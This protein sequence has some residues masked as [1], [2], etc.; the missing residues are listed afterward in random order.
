MPV[1]AEVIAVLAM[2]A[3][4]AATFATYPALWRSFRDE[5]RRIPPERRPRAIDWG[6]T[7]L[8]LA[9]LAAVLV[10]VAPWGRADLA[11]IIL[12]GIGGQMLVV[13]V[14]VGLQAVQDTRRASRPRRKS[15]HSLRDE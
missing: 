3:A 11:L 5:W 4:L 7:A 1:V 6:S 9:T 15:G 12:I 13:L 14:A 8:A 10:I 2:L